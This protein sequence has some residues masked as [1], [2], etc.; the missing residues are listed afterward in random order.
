MDGLNAVDRQTMDAGC[1][2]V[3]FG[4][5]IDAQA[6]EVVDATDVWPRAFEVKGVAGDSFG[7]QA[8]QKE[9]GAAVNDG[10]QLDISAANELADFN[11]HFGGPCEGDGAFLHV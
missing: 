4:H 9:F 6:K 8:G 1:T 3:L 7:T 2:H 5:A 10:G 11:A